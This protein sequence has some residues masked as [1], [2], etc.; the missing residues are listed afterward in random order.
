MCYYLFVVIEG[1]FPDQLT[2]AHPSRREVKRK[3]ERRIKDRPGCLKMI[4]STLKGTGGAGPLTYR[5]PAE[6]GFG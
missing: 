3:M 2:G 1:A 5:N 4:A 6:V